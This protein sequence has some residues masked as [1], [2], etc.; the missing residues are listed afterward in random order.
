VFLNGTFS[1]F[2]FVFARCLVYL[3]NLRMKVDNIHFDLDVFLDKLSDIDPSSLVCF[4]WVSSY[5]LFLNLI[6]RGSSYFC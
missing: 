4:W 6:L 1:S 2:L 3:R 5:I